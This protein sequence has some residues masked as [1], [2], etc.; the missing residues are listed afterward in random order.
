MIPITISYSL[1]SSTALQTVSKT[2]FER[3]KMFVLCLDHSSDISGEESWS[4]RLPKEI[5]RGVVV[6]QSLLAST[7]RTHPIF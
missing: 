3:N 6:V 7:E 4:V 1:L 5:V 2:T